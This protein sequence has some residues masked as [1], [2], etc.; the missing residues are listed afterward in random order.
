MLEETSGGPY[1]NLLLKV[2]QLWSQ[3]RLFRALPSSIY[4]TSKDGDCTTSLG[5]LSHYLTVLTEKNVPLD[6][7]LALKDITW[8]F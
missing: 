7:S 3:T 1:P 5:N 2:S 8:S 4:N 6:S